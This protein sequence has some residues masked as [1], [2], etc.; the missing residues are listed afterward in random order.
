MSSSF[1]FWVNAGNLTLK[2]QGEVI[3]VDKEGFVHVREDN[4]NVVF[5]NPSA[6]VVKLPVE[7]KVVK[8]V[9]F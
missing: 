5:L 7:K 1:I 2:Y 6:I 4:N 8:R 3:G 9:D